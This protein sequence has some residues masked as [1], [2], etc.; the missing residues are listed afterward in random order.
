[1]SLL[2][3]IKIH[4]EGHF[5]KGTFAANHFSLL[6]LKLAIVHIVNLVATFLATEDFHIL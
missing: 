3:F 6:T 5:V 1:M 2:L 4:E